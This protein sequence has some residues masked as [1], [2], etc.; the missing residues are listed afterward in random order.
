MTVV[1][2][3]AETR[4]YYGL[5]AAE[6]KSLA[7][8]APPSL[9]HYT[10][11]TVLIAILQSCAI[12]C[13]HVSCLNDA[14]EIHHAASLLTQAVRERWAKTTS[15]TPEESCL[16]DALPDR[17]AD[18]VRLSR[19]FVTCFTTKNDDLSQ[20]RAYS[21]GEGGYAIGFDT[22]KMLDAFLNSNSV[23]AP[24]VYDQSRQM[25]TCRQ[26]VERAFDAYRQGLTDRPGVAASEW[27]TVFVSE[28]FKYADM[29]L[30]MLKNAAFSDE[31]EWRII[32]SLQPTD[33][34]Q[35]IYQ[36]KSSMMTRHLPMRPK[37]RRPAAVK[38]LPI[39]EIV[40]GPSRHKA[41]STIG[42]NDLLRTLGYPDGSVEVSL[43]AIPF[44][45]P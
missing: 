32:R 1:V 28:W 38:L 5:V 25:Q 10:S 43:S 39:S 44:Q 7:P 2:T 3:D 14:A 30:P 15:R 4:H 33:V 13:T 8:P 42:V 9:W 12:W 16:Y 41:I 26:I 24:V 22:A 23:I 35:M 27:A 21:G 19:W 31:S 37:L 17:L 20:W 36:Q 18:D 40:V 29:L 6:L 34:G 45:L 11:G